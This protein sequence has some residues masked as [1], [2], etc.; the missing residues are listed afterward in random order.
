MPLMAF[1]RF[2][3]FSLVVIFLV[4]AR[5]ERFPKLPAPY[6]TPS[7]Q[8]APEVLG[9]PMGRTP[10]APK[11]FKVDL[12]VDLKSPRSLYLL[13]NGDVLVS[14]SKKKS[15]N[16]GE[17]SPNKISLLKM[18]GNE[19]VRVTN[20]ATGLKL[21]FGMALWRDQFFVAEPT[22][23]LAY[24]YKNERLVGRPKVIAFLPF[25]SP[26]RH[27]TRHLLL[28]PDGKKLYVSV[29]SASNVGEDQDPLDPR[30]AAIL[31]M[32]LDGTQKRIYANGLRNPV[33]MAWEPITG[34][35][36]TVVN[37]RDELGDDLVPDYI[38]PVQDG[39]FYGWPYDYWG[40]HEDPRMK[41]KRPDLV[42]RSL[43]PYFSMGAHTASLGITF[44]QGTLMPKPYNE[45]AFI[46]QH[47]SWNRSRLAGYKV[48][49]VGFQKG[50]AV[51]RESD[52]LTGF[53]LDPVKGTVFGRPVASLIL[54][55]GTLLV[56]DDGDGKIWRV[57][58]LGSY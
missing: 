21:P 54:A 2:I 29:G 35:L 24:K 38:T 7:V 51:D 36:W 11:G 20:F 34:R 3:F 6:E 53:V 4:A 55:D 31:E 16:A 40:R 39:G 8:K 58:P 41:G 37:E 17:S 22:R 44:S 1:I 12:L 45:G 9:W 56:T 25:P 5:A 27:W 50:Y 49:Y 10:K 33:S 57:R 46:V 14:Q 32:N 23:V 26:Q 48:R 13:P 42:A 43:T 30:T 52:F 19:L 15:D 47:G 18:K 28:R